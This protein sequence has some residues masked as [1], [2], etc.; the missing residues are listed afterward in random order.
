MSFKKSLSENIA[1]HKK[2]LGLEQPV[3]KALN[4]SLLIRLKSLLKT[5]KNLNLNYTNQIFLIYINEKK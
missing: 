3:E 2:V 4:P 5:V 1:V